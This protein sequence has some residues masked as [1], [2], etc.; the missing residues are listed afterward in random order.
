MKKIIIFLI[1]SIAALAAKAET[2]FE[3]CE[4]IPDI[5]TVYV[6]KAMLSLAGNL[7]INS[8][9]MDFND[10]AAKMDGLWVINAE[11]KQAA[12]VK[13]LAN[14]AF[15][16]NKYGKLMSVRQEG[17]TVDIFTKNDGDIIKD[18]IIKVIEPDEATVVIIKGNFTLQDIMNAAKA[19]R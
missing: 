4:K 9:G 19:A 2:F 15:N 13:S 10:L 5:T 18:C 1:I 17:R 3:S 8:G 6:S 16:D 11:G 7:N 12:T 14:N